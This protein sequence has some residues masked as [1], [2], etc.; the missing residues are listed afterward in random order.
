M[1]DFT[2]YKYSLSFGSNTIFAFK[3]A[4]VLTAQI[5]FDII[6]VWLLV[7]K[8]EDLER[9]EFYVTGTGVPI[10][11][12]LAE[13]LSFVATVQEVGGLVWHVFEVRE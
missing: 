11:D 3:G 7:D 12:D 9:R 10:Q 5:Q 6:V 13:A 2:V 4:K 1:K 8:K